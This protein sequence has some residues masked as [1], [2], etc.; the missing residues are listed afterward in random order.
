MGR[1]G[2][3][4]HKNL[5][6]GLLLGVSLA[7]CPGLWRPLHSQRGPPPHWLPGVCSR[8]MAVLLGKW[9]LLA[10]KRSGF[11]LFWVNS[12][13]GWLCPCPSLPILGSGPQPP[14]GALL[15][16]SPIHTAPQSEACWPLIPKGHS[17]RTLRVSELLKE[18]AHPFLLL[19]LPLFFLRFYLFI[20]Q[21]QMERERKHT[22]RQ[23]RGQRAREKQMPHGAG[24]P[25]RDSIPGPRGHDLSPRQML[26]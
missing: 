7:S 19:C 3:L 1:G 15:L 6:P 12:A 23:S 18:S 2:Q 22:S 8:D 4:L 17:T 20:G 14:P 9:I 16:R 24:S 25:M 5:T 11:E 26:H 21:R 10:T 13:D